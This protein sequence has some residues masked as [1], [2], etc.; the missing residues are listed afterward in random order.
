M[1]LGLLICLPWSGIRQAKAQYAYGF[2]GPNNDYGNGVVSDGAGGVFMTG[3][4]RDTIDFDPG[5]GVEGRTSVGSDDIF[6]VRYDPNGVPVFVHT[7]GS[8]VNDFGNAVASDGAGGVVM[9]GQFQETV[10][11]DPGPGLA[12]LTS[13]GAYDIVM[14]R[15]DGEG[16]LIY[17]HAIG[18]PDLDG[19][20]SVTPD[21]AGGVFLTG[22]FR[23]TV[24]LDPGPETLTFE[25]VGGYDLFI[26]RYDA[27]GDLIF[28]HTFGSIV[29]DAGLAAAPDGNGGVYVTGSYQNF[30]DIDPGPGVTNLISEGDDDIF[31]I[32]FDAEGNL[33]FGHGFG[34]ASLEVGFGI[35]TDGN[36][37][38]FITGRMQEAIDFDPGLDTLLLVSEGA[39]DIFLAHYDNQGAVVFAHRFGSIANDFGTALAP[40]GAGGVFMTGSYR[41]RV[42]L[43]AGPGQ[44]EVTSQGSGDTFL[45]RY[46]G[47]GDLLFTFNLGGTG[48]DRSNDLAP[49]GAGGVFMT[50]IFESTVDF[51]P[52]AGTTLLTSQGRFDAFVARYTADGL[53][54]PTVTGIHSE[55]IASIPIRADLYPN[56]F[57]GRTQI[58]Y[59]LDRSSSVQLKILRRTGPDRA[60]AH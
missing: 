35:A 51:D 28:A 57:T 6:L 41:G 3:S 12:E 55:P 31:L 36:G 23:G 59:T 38:A 26:A 32:R 17:A 58:T 52:G 43:D 10:D 5:P 37:G 14:A 45:A 56:P 1:L 47:E 22:Q 19:S 24:D 50:G 7:F 25:P 15:Y 18:S 34:S 16:R 8:L 44:T 9:I 60:G 40:D 42:D 21:G 46:N 2:G 11:F 48:F 27:Q 33:V 13:K 53:L 39:G 49:D 29:L 54:Q 20:T 4:F 30:I